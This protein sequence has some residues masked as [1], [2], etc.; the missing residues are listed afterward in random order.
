MEGRTVHFKLIT[1]Q[2]LCET[3][4]DCCWNYPQNKTIK[5]KCLVSRVINRLNNEPDMQI[6]VEG[7]PCWP[8]Q[9]LV[10][11]TLLSF[12]SKKYRLE[13]S[14]GFQRDKNKTLVW[15]IP[16]KFQPNFH[17]LCCL[18]HYHECFV[19]SEEASVHREFLKWLEID[20]YEEPL[21]HPPSQWIGKLEGP[22]KKLALHKYLN[23]WV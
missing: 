6:K 1:Q 9:L 13:A 22:Q 8:C 4:S 5:L 23:L 2:F 21:L 16:Y 11:S 7:K 3:F 17:F 19:P 18:L 20:F 10:N 12:V 15:I 14:K